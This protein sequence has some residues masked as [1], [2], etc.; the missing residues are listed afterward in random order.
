[1]S[2]RS[3]L[4]LAVPIAWLGC[5]SSSPPANTDPQ[6]AGATITCTGGD[7]YTANLVKPSQT[8]KYA[9]TLVQGS[10]APPSLREN[11]WTLKIVD[12]T[13][14]PPPVSQ[15]YAVPCMPLMGHGTDE[16]PQ[17][18][19]NPDGTFTMSGVLLFMDGLWTVTV[20]VNPPNAGT[21]PE[22][23]TSTGSPLDKTVFS[24]C[25]NG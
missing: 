25:I 15:L 7:T 12:P 4:L 2:T 9:F 22:T 24:F 16:I 10:P 11:S 3:L 5:S 20:Y 6:D 14:T 21:T 8:G 17:F 23:C 1:M 18:T 13:G 19:A